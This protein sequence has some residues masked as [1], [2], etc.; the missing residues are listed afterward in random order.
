MVREPLD[1]WHERGY[2]GAALGAYVG[3][4]GA[5]LKPASGLLECLAKTASG[6]GSAV[7][8]WGEAPVRLALKLPPRLRGLGLPTRVS[9]KPRL[10]KIED[11]A[12]TLFCLRRIGGQVQSSRRI[13]LHLT[14]TALEYEGT[15]R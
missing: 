9:D 5:V 12:R 6:V 11:C 3:I 14:G 8:S 2:V 10:S 4:A 15:T 1:G 7:L 13:P